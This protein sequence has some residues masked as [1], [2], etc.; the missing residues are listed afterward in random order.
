[1]IAE[2]SSIFWVNLAASTVFLLRAESI[3]WILRANNEFGLTRK[4][5]HESVRPVWIKIK[6]IINAEN[7]F[8]TVYPLSGILFGL[9]VG[10]LS[11]WFRGRKMW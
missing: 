2:A 4:I 7:V 1:M 5:S 9:W 6:I 8:G 3:F 10:G 11:P